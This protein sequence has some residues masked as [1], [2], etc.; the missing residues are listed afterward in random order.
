[1]HTTNFRRFSLNL[2]IAEVFK[3]IIVDRVIF[4]LLNKKMIDEKDFIEELGGIYLKEKGQRVFVEQFDNRLRTTIS[5]KGLG[6]NISYR[7]LIRRELYKL[8][9]DLMGDREYKPFVARW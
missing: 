7:S 2:D 8:E 3:P 4:T 1:M 6:R 5:D 9:K